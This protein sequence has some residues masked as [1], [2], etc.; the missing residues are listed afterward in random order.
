MAEF[1][2]ILS[3]IDHI[4]R[5][6]LSKAEEPSGCSLPE[7]EPVNI[8]HR[9]VLRSQG[10]LPARKIEQAQALFRHENARLNELFNHILHDV[11]SVL[12]TLI[13]VAVISFCEE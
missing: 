8:A 9:F 12:E 5:L 11:T 4:S 13:Y 2:K 1:G 7:F 6:E 10:T 3:R